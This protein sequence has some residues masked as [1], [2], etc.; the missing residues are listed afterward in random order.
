M[1]AMRVSFCLTVGFLIYFV[2]SSRSEENVSFGKAATQSSDHGIR[3]NASRA[4]DG[5]LNRELRN[6]GCCSHTDP[7]DLKEAWWQV[8]LGSLST[9][10]YITIYHRSD[11]D[12]RSRFAGYQLYMSNT[13][14]WSLG[15]LCY[16]DR[17]N[18]KAQVQ[19]VVTHQCPYVA[20]YVTIYI[21][22]GNP[23]RYVWYESRAILE[24]CEVQ[25][26]GCPIDKHG[27][28][29]C[30]QTCSDNCYGGN[31]DAST[32]QCFYCPSEMRGSMC[33]LDCSSN[34]K[35]RV[36]DKDSGYCEECIPGKYG[37][38][39]EQDCTS[40]C[41]DGVC[42]KDTSH[43]YKCIPGKYGNSCGQDCSSNC[44]DGVCVKDT[45]HCDGCILGKRGDICELDCPVNCQDSKCAQHTGYC[46]ACITGR[47]G[48]FCLNTCPNNCLDNTCEKNNGQ[49]LGKYGANCD[50]DCSE[51]CN[52][53][54]CMQISGQCKECVAAKY[55]S[56][57]EQN[58][59]PDCKDNVCSINEGK[60]L[61]CTTGRYGETCTFTCPVTCKEFM[62]DQQTGQCLDCYPGKYGVVCG[63]DCPVTCQDNI[64]NK[65]NGECLTI[66]TDNRLIVIAVLAVICGLML[67]VF[68]TLE[69]CLF[70]KIRNKKGSSHKN[71]E[72]CDPDRTY[73]TLSGSQEVHPNVYEMIDTK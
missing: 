5:C 55:G 16:E 9:I 6:S 14:D 58:C 71:V 66:G 60:C 42:A 31:C 56:T 52:N 65:D 46:S 49:C 59:P 3:L 38:S 1:D 30:D 36:C 20:Q 13:T 48:D 39:C 63:A 29:T 15:V 26:F 25:V 24:L 11:F 62:C 43:C 23:K 33:D 22:R 47:H 72:P 10:S 8:D 2:Q 28:G 40:N 35:D 12:S 61:H 34:C 21:Y 53:S 18:T 64:C 50:L 54:V 17:S 70:R 69:I 45:G 37:N 41:K 27:N 67:V 19:M 32:G 7:R 4:V 68:I 44:K 51:H 73:T 57:C